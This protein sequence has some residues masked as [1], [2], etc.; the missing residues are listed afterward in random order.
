MN[1]VFLS[2]LMVSLLSAC[3][4]QAPSPQREAGQNRGASPVPQAELPAAQAPEVARPEQPSMQPV[5]VRPREPVSREIPVAARSLLSRAESAYAKGDYSAAIA[6]AERGLRIAR[7]SP[8]ILWLLA[9]SY[10]AQHDVEQARVF[11]QQGLRFA[12]ADDRR[13]RRQ[14]EALIKRLAN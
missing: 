12:P 8:E 3:A 14:F 10:E 2:V 7:T 13:T 4:S 6:S 5:P 11:A 1:K 9:R